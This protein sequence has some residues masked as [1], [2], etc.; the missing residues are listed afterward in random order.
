ESV[1]RIPHITYV[2]DIDMT[3]VE[4]LRAHLN[5]QNKGT[6]KPKLNVLPFIARAIV[7]ALKDQPNIN[8]T[9]DD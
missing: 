3:A 1:R 6:G 8:A 7:V 9:Y 2:E 4:E 5:A